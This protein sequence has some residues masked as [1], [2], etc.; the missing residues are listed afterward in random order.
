MN[1]MQS[2]RIQCPNCGADYE[3]ERQRIS[4]PD[5]HT[6]LAPL[7]I[8]TCCAVCGYKRIILSDPRK[9]A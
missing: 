4:L 8:P 2:V 5:A 1:K 3:Q 7:V 6:V 9:A